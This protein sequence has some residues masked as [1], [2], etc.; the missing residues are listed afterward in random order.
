MIDEFW[1]AVL[2][3]L[4]NQLSNEKPSPTTYCAAFFAGVIGMLLLMIFCFCEGTGWSKGID[5]FLGALFTPLVPLA[6][7]GAGLF[8]MAILWIRIEH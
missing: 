8:S 2:G 5:I 4:T 7:V 1:S 3:S 6:L